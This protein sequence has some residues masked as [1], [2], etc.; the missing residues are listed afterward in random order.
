MP[1]DGSKNSLKALDTAVG[2]ARQAGA[3]IELIYI[4]PFP[5]VQAYQPDR[6]A[7]ERMYEEAT[8]FLKS[9]IKKASQDNADVKSKILKGNPGLVIADYANNPKNKVDLIVIGSRGLSGLREKF[10][11]SVSSYVMH[12]SNVPVLVVK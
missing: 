9:S 7:K 3:G 8:R 6:I 2:L 12:K 1:L 11:G 4:L 10:L 5:T